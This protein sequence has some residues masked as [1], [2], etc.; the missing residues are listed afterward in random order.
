MKIGL[1]GGIGCGKSTFAQLLVQNGFRHISTD[2]VARDILAA[3]ET[4]A[5]LRDRFGPAVIAPDGT[6]DRPALARIVFAD[7]AALADLEA[8]L[9]PRTQA[10]W[11]AQIDADPSARWV[12]EIPLLFEKNLD[13]VFDLTVCVHCSPSIQLSRLA[14]RGVSPDQAAARIA[15][16]LPLET[17]VGRATLAVFNDGTPAFLAAQARTLCAHPALAAHP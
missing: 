13:A 3:P 2:L 5:W 12:V 6:P 7:P 8:R 9:H 17:K 10:A 15:A 1:T 16:Q 4:I 14:A 11:R